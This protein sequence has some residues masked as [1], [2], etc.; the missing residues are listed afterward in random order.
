MGEEYYRTSGNAS[1]CHV[2]KGPHWESSLAA[3]PGCTGKKQRESQEFIWDQA[4]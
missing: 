3:V 1:L 4:T 2:G